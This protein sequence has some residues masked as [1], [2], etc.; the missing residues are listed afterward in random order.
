MRS[1]GWYTHV[2]NKTLD[3][4]AADDDDDA[5]NDYDD[6]NDGNKLTNGN[7]CAKTGLG[8]ICLEGGKQKDNDKKEAFGR[9][10]G[11]VAPLFG[12]LCDTRFFFYKKP[13][14]SAILHIS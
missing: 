12:D 9:H 8:T 6:D 7:H 3:S 11:E 2:K 10:H 14:F 4:G 13:D 1:K 5:T